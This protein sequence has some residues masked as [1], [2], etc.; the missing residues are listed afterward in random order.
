MRMAFKNCMD[1]RKKVLQAKTKDLTVS[2]YEHLTDLIEANLCSKGDTKYHDK[3][4]ISRN[5]ESCGIERLQQLEEEIDTTANAP[6][7]KWQ[8]LE[9]VNFQQADGQE[10]RKL[11]IV[12]K[13]TSHLF[14]HLK[15]LVK[16]FLSHQFRA[17]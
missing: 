15:D 12:I 4:C 17:S 11:Q 6:K 13:E 10:K 16:S 7:V 8:R 9:N 3:A 2:V 5:C 14:K 1:F